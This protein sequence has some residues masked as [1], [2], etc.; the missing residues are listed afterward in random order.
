M[1]DSSSVIHPAKV[2]G[3]WKL[4]KDTFEEIVIPTA[5]HKEILKGKET[6]SP[7][8]PVIESSINEGWVRVARA[9]RIT[10]L[11]DN[12]GRGEKEALA[13]MR[14]ERADWLLMDDLVASRTA[15]LMGIEVRPVVYLL[16]YWTR[17]GVTRK[18]EAIELLEELV[19][20]G[21]GLSARDYL[22]I[23]QMILG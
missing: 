7:D 19:T 16:I 15:T 20:T 23:K 10:G 4:M 1:A 17:K 13:L 3:F 12:L 2:P 11:P 8:V 18:E 6:G 9:P 14:K 5:V 22:A 21:Y